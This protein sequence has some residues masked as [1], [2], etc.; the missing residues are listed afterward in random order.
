MPKLHLAE[1][2][3]EI[4]NGPVNLET[5]VF[6]TKFNPKTGQQ[7][8]HIG[9]MPTSTFNILATAGDV[10]QNLRTALDHLA[11][12]L[13]QVGTPGVKP[14]NEVSFPIFWSVESYNK[15]KG[16]RSEE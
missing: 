10:I 16:K 5:H 6:C 11:Y 15:K 2:E 9:P 14:H 3:N 8:P 1:L 13:V 4:Q 12:H 7:E